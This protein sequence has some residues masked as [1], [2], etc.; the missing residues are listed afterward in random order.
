MTEI[1]VTSSVLILCILLI[2][3]IFRGKVSSRLLYALW[4]LAALRLMIPISARMD[5]GFFS[6]LRPTE[7]VRQAQES[8]GLS[9]GRLE[10]PIQ[11]SVNAQ[12]P[13][14]RFL[15]NGAAREVAGEM[16]ADGPTSVFIA[17]RL[18]FARMDILRF[19]WKAGMVVV[20][21]W[22]AAANF[23]FFRRLRRERK[24]F[25]LPENLLE[26]AGMKKPKNVRVYTAAY[27][28]SPCLYGFP[29]RE[30]VYLTAD[31]AE[32]G[33][34]LKHVIVHE[35]VHRKHG[36]S[37]WALLRSILVIVYWFHPLVWAA[38]VCSRRDCELACDEGALVFLG[39]EER[40]PY[41]ETLLSIIT[42]RGRV[43][44]LV[45][46][47][48]TMT[49]SAKRV[50]E[51]IQFII[52]KPGMLYAA[53][54]ALILVT[55][56]ICLLVFTGDVWS[57]GIMVD[58]E[59]GLTVTG[60]D[61]QI[62]L[63]ASIGG[64]SGCIVEG[65]EEDIVVYHQKARREVGRFSRMPLKDAL[66]LVDEGREVTPLGNEGDNY[67]LRAY[68]GE[69]LVRIEHTYTPAGVPG[70]DSNSVTIHSYTSEDVTRIDG[71]DDTTY[72]IDDETDHPS[73]ET[74]AEESVTYLPNEAI[75]VTHQPKEVNVDD[76]EGGCFLY[77]RADFG[78]VSKKYMEE[79]TFIDGELKTAGEGAVILSL[80]RKR[81]E[82]LFDIL[83]E[84][85]TPFVG[86]NSKVG[87]LLAAIPVPPSLNRSEGFQLQTTEEPYALLFS[88]QMSTDSLSQEDEDILYLNAA[89][90]FYA[91]GNVE[92]ITMDIQN[93]GGPDKSHVRVYKREDMAAALPDL[94]S[95]DYEDGQVFRDGLVRLYTAVE[96]HLSAA[97][98][99]EK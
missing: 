10:E 43:S 25:T 26:T 3:R 70:T 20:A 7:L 42:G 88:Y 5:L 50:K 29:G 49:G 75:T 85:R 61:M 6:Q 51:R 37:F 79:M 62:H 21:V 40:I 63:P 19:I 12:N 53:A 18:G 87:A 86:D 46:T 68:L 72:I 84:N 4:L 55:A 97:S 9:E 91:V 47:A 82:K 99:L 23:L 56:A 89:M 32:D 94:Q 17:G 95:A 33:D 65:E 76:L 54:A 80:N 92:E 78:D 83:T 22:M 28:R 48:T 52:R 1:I 11:I 36:D 8:V 74:M 24:E 13:L 16:A 96:A 71:S 31:V 59:A 93:P 30:A 27:L 14:F 69:P 57:D 67:L 60:A 98:S 15:V 2:R 64:I 44:D 38:A 34:K 58:R 41:G 45:C 39:E 81:R 73:E 35:L 66:Q 90:L 77:I